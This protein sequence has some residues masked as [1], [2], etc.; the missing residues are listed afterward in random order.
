MPGV[1]SLDRG[2]WFLPDPHGIDH[3]ACV[4]VLTKEKMSPAVAFAFNS[5]LV[6]VD[7]AS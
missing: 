2:A 4:N 5:C 1:V 6:E 3:G 7:L